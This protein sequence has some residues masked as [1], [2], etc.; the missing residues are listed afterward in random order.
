[1]CQITSSVLQDVLKMSSSSTNES[2]ERWHHSTTH[3][4]T[5]DLEQLSRCWC[6]T[7]VHW[8]TII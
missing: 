7:S 2:D 4:I 6:I 8:C 1:M 3:L 5:I